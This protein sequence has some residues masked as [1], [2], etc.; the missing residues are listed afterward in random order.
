LVHYV[1]FLF[2]SSILNSFVHITQKCWQLYECIDVVADY[3]ILWILLC[4]FDNFIHLKLNVSWHVCWGCFKNGSIYYIFCIRVL[5]CQY[6]YPCD[7]LV[8]FLPQIHYHNDHISIFCC[9]FHD[10][11]W[12]FRYISYFVIHYLGIHGC[13]F[14]D[15]YPIS[16]FISM[17]LLTWFKDEKNN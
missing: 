6:G 5:Y 1:C 3:L 4:K 14:I 12:C 10:M 2:M 11:I 9:Y 8:G 7:P 16:L 17:Y 15:I 13:C